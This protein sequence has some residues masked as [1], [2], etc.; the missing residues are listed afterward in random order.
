MSAPATRKAGPSAQTL[1]GRIRSELEERIISGEWKP[2]FRLPPEMELASTYGCARMTVNKVLGAMVADGL[3]ERRRKLGTIVRHPVEQSAILDISDIRDE[4]EAA[5]LV[6]RF[7]IL[8]RETRSATESDRELLG[9]EY[10]GPVLALACL[11]HAGSRRFCFEARLINLEMVPEAAEEEFALVAP[12]PWLLARI[13]WSAA[14]HRISARGA[15]QRIADILG[16]KIGAACLQIERRTF[17]LDRPVTQ[18]RFTYP[19]Q[20]HALTAR[21]ETGRVNLS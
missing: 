17:H 5:G 3:I 18:V 4:V 10:A 14:D 11:H 21:I 20:S 1:H 15:S 13:P 6:Y 7:E 12:G 8:S 19:G 9:L 16:L 2:G